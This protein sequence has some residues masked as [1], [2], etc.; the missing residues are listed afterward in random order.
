MLDA[1]GLKGYTVGGARISP[2][3]RELHRERG[4]RDR[5]GRDRAHGRGA[6][7]SP[8]AIRRR[9]RARGGAARR[10]QP[11]ARR[12][13]AMTRQPPVRRA[14][15]AQGAR[16]APGRRDRRCPRAR[17]DRRRRLASRHG[18]PD[19][20]CVPRRRQSAGAVRPL[21]RR[22]RWEGARRLLLDAVTADGSFLDV[23][24][25]NGHLL[26]CVPPLGRRGRY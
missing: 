19:R 4:R 15:R 1:C 17:R 5:R 11:A 14:R 10:P 23:G 13:A 7:A 6:A 18:R 22:R 9:A 8:R 25:A 26:E 21:R 2:T 3:A 24:C 16:L 20:P 12:R